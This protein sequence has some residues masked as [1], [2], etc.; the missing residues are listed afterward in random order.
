LRLFHPDGLGLASLFTSYAGGIG[1]LIGVA[2][3]G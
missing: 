2:I 1:K 3:S